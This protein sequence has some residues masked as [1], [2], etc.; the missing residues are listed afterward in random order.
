MSSQKILSL[1]INP[2]FPARVLEWSV[3]AIAMGGTA[4]VVTHAF[5]T[6]SDAAARVQLVLQGCEMIV[7]TLIAAAAAGLLHAL[8]GAMEDSARARSD[9]VAA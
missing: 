7:I 5:L 9:L 3:A 2:K 6:T 8:A 1:F 4:L